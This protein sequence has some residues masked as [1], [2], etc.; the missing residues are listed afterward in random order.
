MNAPRR[1]CDH[2]SNLAALYPSAMQDEGGQMVCAIELPT[3]QVSWQVELWESHKFRG[4]QTQAIPFD[5][6]T[7]EEKYRRV[8]AMVNELTPGRSLAWFSLSMLLC[9]ERY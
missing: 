9:L 5:G 1:Q 3:G 4:V 6:H 2:I 7:T 8:E